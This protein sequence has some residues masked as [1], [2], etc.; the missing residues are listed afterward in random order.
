MMAGHKS[1]K[2]ARNI[3]EHSIYRRQLRNLLLFFV[4]AF[5]FFIYDF[6]YHGYFG[7]SIFGVQ[8][9]IICRLE[10]ENFLRLYP[11]ATGNKKLDDARSQARINASPARC[12]YD[13]MTI[14]SL[15]AKDY[16]DTVQGQKV[17]AGNPVTPIS[18]DIGNVILLAF[19]LFVFVECRKLTPR[20]VPQP[21][22][23]GLAAVE[24]KFSVRTRYLGGILDFALPAFSLIVVWT[25]YSLL[26]DEARW[27][28]WAPT[29][30]LGGLLAILIIAPRY[31]RFKLWAITKSSKGGR[32]TRATTGFERRCEQLADFWLEL[33]EHLAA[34]FGGALDPDVGLFPMI[35]IFGTFLG[36]GLAISDQRLLNIISSISDDHPISARDWTGLITGV[37]VAIFASLFGTITAICARMA[38]GLLGHQG[39]EE[40]VKRIDVP[41]PHTPRDPPA[42]KN[43]VNGTTTSGKPVVPEAPSPP[44]QQKTG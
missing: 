12:A 15:A 28:G 13:D 30:F 20:P 33:R 10:Y 11:G 43:R 19:L 29:V 4:I 3:V 8:P 31:E 17:K 5:H 18:S 40:Q 24:Q 23:N 16:V 22:A 9:G 32:T 14:K 38:V 26:S 44:E 39:E 42:P 27:T 7:I 35:G 41:E 25:V 37:G 1:P 34:L 6:I 36:L 21:R 2:L